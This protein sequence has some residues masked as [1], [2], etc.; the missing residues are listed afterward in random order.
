MSKIFLLGATGFIGK[1][2]YRRISDIH[3]VVTDMR[4]FDDRYDVIIYLAGVTHTYNIFDPKLIEAN[5]ILADKVFKRPERII[6][7]SSCSAAHFTNPYAMSKQWCEYLGEKHG[8]AIGLRFFNV[9]GPENNK[10]IVKFLMNQPDGSTITIRGPELVRD[11]IH[12]DDVIDC[13]IM[14][15]HPKPILIDMEYV[16]KTVETIGYNTELLIKM[17]MEQNIHIAD[18]R[19]PKQCFNK[20]QVIEVGTGVGTETMDLVNLYMELSGKRFT[21]NVVEAGDHEPKEMVAK[22]KTLCL[23]L[24]EGLLKTI[25]SQ[26]CMIQ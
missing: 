4:Y 11:Y 23:S 15:L 13:I 9:Y 3:E 20:S 12:V 7:A 26:P 21:I 24:R 10:G 14:Q 1:Y 2:L 17:A 25:N 5:I 22:Q 18:L 16:N 6:Y 19:T 8:N